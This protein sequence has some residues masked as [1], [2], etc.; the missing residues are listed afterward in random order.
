ML[1]IVCDVRRECGRSSSETFQHVSFG[2]GRPCAIN[3]GS[4]K[5]AFTKSVRMVNVLEGDP[6]HSCVGVLGLVLGDVFGAS[7]SDVALN[8]CGL[9]PVEVTFSDTNLHI[10]IV[11]W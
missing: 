5:R 7:A 1:K 3:G 10:A 4:T 11:P 6:H 2:S 9:S 8:R